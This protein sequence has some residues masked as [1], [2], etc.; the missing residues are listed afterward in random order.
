MYNLIGRGSHVDIGASF[1]L[2][3]IASRFLVKS[4]ADSERHHQ[5]L[6]TVLQNGTTLGWWRARYFRLQP[7]P[8]IES[9]PSPGAVKLDETSTER[10]TDMIKLT[11]VWMAAHEKLLA[12]TAAALM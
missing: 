2:K 8:L 10:L 12:D 1:M 4:V 9:A 11:R 6:A 7:G 5:F 3:E